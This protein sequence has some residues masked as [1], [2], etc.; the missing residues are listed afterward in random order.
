MDFIKKLAEAT[1]TETPEEVETSTKCSCDCEA[2]KNCDKETPE[3]D[4][5]E[6]GEE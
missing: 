5:M 4:T 3:E 6:N 2:C 1:K